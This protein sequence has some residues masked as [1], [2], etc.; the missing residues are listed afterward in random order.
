MLLKQQMTQTAEEHLFIIIIE[1]KKLRCEEC[2]LNGLC[3]LSIFLSLT[4]KHLNR[5]IAR[6]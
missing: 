6:N 3:P 2:Y 1:V 5:L 4:E